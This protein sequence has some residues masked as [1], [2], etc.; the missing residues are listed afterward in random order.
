VSGR[1]AT[2]HPKQQCAGDSPPVSGIFK[3]LIVIWWM[4]GST[5]TTQARSW[6]CW[7]GE[8]SYKSET[9][10]TGLWSASAR[11]YGGAEA[12]GKRARIEAERTGTC[13]IS[14]DRPSHEPHVNAVAG[15][16][17]PPWPRVKG[18]VLPGSSLP[19]PTP[20][21][22]ASLLTAEHGTTDSRASFLCAFVEDYYE[23]FERICSNAL[24]RACFR[25]SWDPKGSPFFHPHH[26]FMIL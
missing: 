17:L 23:E 2:T 22:A 18:P 15:L 3:K 6:F 16:G 25:M 8:E 19:V 4:G 26:L 7:I 21:A 12:C 1:V 13:I 9:D 20:E 5:T 10:Q 11:I 14:Q 24:E